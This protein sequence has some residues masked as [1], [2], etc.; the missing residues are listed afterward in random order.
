MPTGSDDLRGF[1]IL[2]TLG[3]ARDPIP[4]RRSEPPLIGELKIKGGSLEQPY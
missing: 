2:E 3:M 1:Q 4:L